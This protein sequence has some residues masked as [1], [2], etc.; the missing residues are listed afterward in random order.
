MNFKYSPIGLED[1][2][3]SNGKNN[4]I[5]FLNSSPAG[6]I[7]EKQFLVTL[8]LFCLYDECI[9][10]K[11]ILDEVT[12]IGIH[13]EFD[14]PNKSYLLNIKIRIS[15]ERNLT[16]FDRKKIEGNQFGD[17]YYDPILN[18]IYLG[19]EYRLNEQEVSYFDSLRR[20][21]AIDSIC[22]SE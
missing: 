6:E 15:I 10:Q 5:N 20:N 2:L 17:Y 11:S 21:Y 19:A 22:D 9:G 12:V 13:T 14:M 7:L 3:N 16:F 4:I 18:E 1:W 8:K